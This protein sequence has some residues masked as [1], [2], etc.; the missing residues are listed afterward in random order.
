MTEGEFFGEGKKTGEKNTMGVALKK[1]F[2][3]LIQ[4]NF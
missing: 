1:N 2:L 3:F 4:Q